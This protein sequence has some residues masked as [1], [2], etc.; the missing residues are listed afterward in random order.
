MKNPGFIIGNIVIFE[1]TFIA[2]P[3][4][5]GKIVGAQYKDNNWIYKISPYKG[6]LYDVEEKDIYKLMK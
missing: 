1:S 6:G 5:Q 3:I 4:Q 2:V